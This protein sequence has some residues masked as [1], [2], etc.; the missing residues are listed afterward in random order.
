MLSEI[1][2]RPS[3]SNSSVASLI[4]R[5]KAISFMKIESLV[6][7]LSSVNDAKDAK[8]L[9]I[10]L[11]E[12]TGRVKHQFLLIESQ[13]PRGRLWTRLERA[14]DE[15]H[16]R[17]IISSSSTFQANDTAMLAS[18]HDA[19]LGR[20]KSE[21][22]GSVHFTGP[23]TVT[24]SVLQALLSSFI[25]MSKDYTAA[26]ENC[27]FFCSVVISVLS[28]NYPHWSHGHLGHWGN[29]PLNS[30][31]RIQEDFLRKMNS[32]GSNSAHATVEARVGVSDRELASRSKDM[33]S[34]NSI[35]SR[36]EPPRI[37]LLHGSLGSTYRTHLTIGNRHGKSDRCG[38][39]V[40][41]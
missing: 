33:S 14:A 9:T 6:E 32:L 28:D 41:Y 24:L 23:N 39:T 20:R 2:H 37:D 5:P 3:P 19:L 36:S 8:V 11:R 18:S 22:K 30:K 16:R 4:P 26:V 40:L 10:I 1:V 38:C 31:D 27:W 12:D 17:G 21:E 15:Y 25:A 29:V 7:C 35:Q 34:P 13:T